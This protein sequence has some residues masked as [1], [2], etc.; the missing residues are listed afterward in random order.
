MAGIFEKER[1][2][3]IVEEVSSERLWKHT[4]YI[5]QS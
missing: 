2:R 4:A 1:E 3:K 5:V